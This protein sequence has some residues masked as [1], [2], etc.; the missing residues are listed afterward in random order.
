[1]SW[2]DT[3]VRLPSSFVYMVSRWYAFFTP[4]PNASTIALLC[5]MSHLPVCH[6][7][8]PRSL[9]SPQIASSFLGLLLQGYGALMAKLWRSCTNL[10]YSG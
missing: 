10:T 8:G 1:M 5:H 3:S 4:I 6:A 9:A 7:A 2:V